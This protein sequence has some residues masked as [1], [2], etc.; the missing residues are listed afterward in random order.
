MKEYVLRIAQSGFAAGEVFDVDATN[1]GT[2][3]NSADIAGARAAEDSAEELRRFDEAVLALK[4]ELSTATQKADENNAAIFE[5]EQMLLE[6]NRFA[7]AVRMLISDSGQD[8]IS[9]K[10]PA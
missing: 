2:A 4:Q 10:L 5:A 6:D 3:E 9:P 8:A 1:A 7:G